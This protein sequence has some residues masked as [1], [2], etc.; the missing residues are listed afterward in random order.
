MKLKLVTNMERSM[1]IVKAEG[2]RDLILSFRW[3]RAITIELENILIVQESKI[4]IL[5][6]DNKD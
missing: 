1:G 6:E 3:A 2:N 5:K 4:W